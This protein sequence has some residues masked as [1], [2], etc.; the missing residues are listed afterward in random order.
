[1]E[2]KPSLPPESQKVAAADC[3]GRSAS[4]RM[5]IFD[6]ATFR[7]VV[8]FIILS[9]KVFFVWFLNALYGLYLLFSFHRTTAAFCRLLVFLHSWPSAC[10]AV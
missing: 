6:W 7:A 1:M 2:G 10:S 4:H 9:E 5:G 8:A 3:E